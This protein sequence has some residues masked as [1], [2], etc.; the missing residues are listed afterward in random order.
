MPIALAVGI[1]LGRFLLP[2]LEGQSDYGI[3]VR[4][5]KSRGCAL[6]VSTNKKILGRDLQ[7][8]EGADFVAC[9]ASKEVA[10]GSWLVCDCSKLP[11]E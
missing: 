11:T 2:V 10:P 1:T 6:F 9:G 8:R 3:Q 7:Q 5:D 4:Q